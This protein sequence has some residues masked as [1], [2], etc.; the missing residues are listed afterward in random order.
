M[1]KMNVCFETL[2]TQC[3]ER[4]LDPLVIPAFEDSLG[5]EELQ[6][7]L[8]QHTKFLKVVQHFFEKFISSMQGV[9]VLTATT[10]KEG[11][12]IQMNGDQTIKDTVNQLGI[13]EGVR[14]TEEHCGINS[15]SLTLKHKQPIEIIGPDHFHHCL[16]A[17]TCYGVPIIDQSEGEI[18]GTITFM[19]AVECGS[20]LLLTL[21]LMMKDSIERELQLLHQNEKLYIIN[22]LIMDTTR[23]GIMISSKSGKLIGFNHSAEHITGLKKEDVLF[24][25]LDQLE[26]FGL[27]LRKVL[28]EG[29]RYTDLEIDFRQK[30]GGRV[31]V[32]FDAL[33]ILDE[34]QKL[35]GS[36]AQIK[37]I[38]RRK[39]TEEL[40]LNAEKLAA[41]GQMAASVA[42]E[43]RNPLTTVRGFIQ[44]IKE[45]FE[46]NSHF[47][48][49][50]DEIDRINF[51]VSEFLILSKPNV[52]HFH[53]KNLKH[54]LEETVVLF[55][56][57]ASM[58]NT[59]IVPD[60]EDGDLLIHCNENQ[61]K[62]VFI[63]L[64]KNSIEAMPFGGQLAVRVKRVEDKEASIQ[65]IDKGEG[66]KPEQI[67]KLG[68]PFY[69]TK[70][71]GTGLGYMV[72]KRIIEQH[73]GRLTIHSKIKE[74]TTVE[75][76]LPLI[77]C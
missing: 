62:Q 47:H 13:K 50:L 43:I 58:N 22:Q 32:L 66:M 2:K 67:Q 6:Q 29:E 18:I 3:K 55:Q 11:Y 41:I 74:G 25:P 60:F 68:T 7:K 70:E 56:V 40:L 75:I 17:C 54:I 31:T 51:I 48:L 16:H 24:Q 23:D 64:F 35:I 77:S 39:R 4:G 38:T 52:V 37:D 12:V 14:F 42:H 27:Y 19:T 46:D 53:P 57:Q 36:F 44:L 71:T 26:S 69:T 5:E 63:N 72:I 15:V 34:K 28:E 8:S 1:G 33:P 65:I 10:D 73:K 45:D 30:S 59:Q 76:T 49:I 21:L 61:L 9:P 20:P